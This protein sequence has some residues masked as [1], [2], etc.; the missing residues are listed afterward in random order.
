MHPT[1][2]YVDKEN[3]AARQFGLSQLL[4]KS[5]DPQAKAFFFST[6]TPNEIQIKNCHKFCK[7]SEFF[8]NS[9]DYFLSYHFTQEFEEWWELH[10]DVV[11]SH[12]LMAQ[13]LVDVFSFLR[14]QVNLCWLA[15]KWYSPYLASFLS[16]IV[17]HFCLS[18]SGVPPNPRASTAGSQ[19]TNTTRI[20]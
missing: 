3:L 7:R 20:S 19:G 13:H 2:L 6:D 15:L 4:P 10:Y 16:W 14:Y 18:F 5:L 17:I 1:H 8:L 11:P 9:F 12:T